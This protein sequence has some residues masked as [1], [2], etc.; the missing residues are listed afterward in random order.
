MRDT[1]LNNFIASKCAIFD[2][3][4]LYKGSSILYPYVLSTLHHLVFEH[5]NLPSHN[6]AAIFNCHF[7]IN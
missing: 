4:S 6:S 1:K 7:Y 2:V 5:L 3:S